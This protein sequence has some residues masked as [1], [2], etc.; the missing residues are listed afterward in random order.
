MGHAATEGCPGECARGSWIPGLELNQQGRW[1]WGWRLT[2]Q[3]RLLL[4]EDPDA[5]CVGLCGEAG[6]RGRG[7]AA[8]TPR[9]QSGAGG[10]DSLVVRG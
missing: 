9:R 7:Q 5:G 6:G 10:G 2:A 3:V 8:E 1:Q 4:P